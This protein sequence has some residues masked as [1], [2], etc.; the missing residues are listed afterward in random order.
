MAHL[1]VRPTPPSK[2]RLPAHPGPSPLSPCLSP[3]PPRGR[4]GPPSGGTT[5][6]GS[7]PGKARQAP[8]P[9]VAGMGSP[10][11]VGSPG[12]AARGSAEDEAAAG[13]LLTD[14]GP[15]SAATLNGSV[16]AAATFAL[17]IGAPQVRLPHASLSLS[18]S[19]PHAP[20]SLSLCIYSM[21]TPYLTLFLFPASEVLLTYVTPI[22]SC[23]FVPKPHP[24]PLHVPPLL[25]PSF[26][27]SNPAPLSYLLP[28]SSRYLCPLSNAISNPFLDRVRPLQVQA[29]AV[30][31]LCGV[32]TG[33]PRLM[34]MA[35]S[36]GLL[37]RLLRGGGAGGGA[38]RAGNVMSEVRWPW[39]CRT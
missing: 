38:G 7:T 22:L 14:L 20:P 29:R 35:Q 39:P 12:G 36:S 27:V 26:T 32:F 19:L 4:D 10:G 1:Q 25:C 21:S 13:T 2:C 30:H 5:P 17:A 9:A 3:P 37:G 24:C 8:A 15:I 31:A 23:L 16:Y 33:C 11:G 28:A 18:L 34:L 6:T